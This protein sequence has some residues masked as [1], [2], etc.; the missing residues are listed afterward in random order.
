MI[1]PITISISMLIPL[2]LPI[3]LLLWK[4]IIHLLIMLMITYLYYLTLSILSI[5]FLS[6][7]RK[8]F[9]IYF[10]T[11]LETLLLAIY[12]LST[13]SIIGISHSYLIWF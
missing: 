11:D 13:I 4:T 2:T 1:I 3:L 7:S 10:M 5:T 9:G 8:Q 6:T 12:V